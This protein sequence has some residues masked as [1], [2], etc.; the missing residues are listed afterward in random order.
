[1]ADHASALIL[2]LQ[3]ERTAC[4]HQLDV[5]RDHFEFIDIDCRRCQAY[6]R[7]EEGVR[8]IDALLAHLASVYPTPPGLTTPSTA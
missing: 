1:M 3:E 2:A 8:L 6:V 4:Q 5:H 7:A